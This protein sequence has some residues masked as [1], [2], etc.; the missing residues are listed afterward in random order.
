MMT[1]SVSSQARVMTRPLDFVYDDEIGVL[2]GSCDDE[3]ARS[4][5]MTRSV[6]SRGLARTLTCTFEVFLLLESLCRAQ[7]LLCLDLALRR[8]RLCFASRALSSTSSVFL[9]SRPRSS[10]RSVLLCFSSP[11]FDELGFCAESIYRL[12]VSA[13]HTNHPNDGVVEGND[14]MEVQAYHP[15]DRVIK[16]RS[17]WRR[18]RC[19]TRLL[20]V[21]EK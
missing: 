2:S 7:F 10:T 5:V 1:R 12:A 11:L 21:F 17:S 3:T 19:S 13:V 16:V 6:L 15:D 14:E 4:C 20:Y 8:D 18:R 9:L